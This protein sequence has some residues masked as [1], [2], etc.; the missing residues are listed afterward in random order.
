MNPLD[1][2]QSNDFQIHHVI[3][4]LVQA[5]VDQNIDNSNQV[6]DQNEGQF[7]NLFNIYQIERRSHEK[8]S[9]PTI[10]LNSEINVNQLIDPKRSISETQFNCSEC[11]EPQTFIEPIA[12][13]GNIAGEFKCE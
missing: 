11:V 5:V 6:N 3:Y 4:D 12:D 10:T 2:E 7:D 1:S 9:N 13:D 8:T